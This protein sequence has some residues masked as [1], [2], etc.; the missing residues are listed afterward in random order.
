MKTSIK[1]LTP[2]EKALHGDELKQVTSKLLAFAP[3]GADYLE[4]LASPA[5]D[6]VAWL[7]GKIDRKKYDRW[8]FVLAKEAIVEMW[9]KVLPKVELK[10]GESQGGGGTDAEDLAYQ[11][12][13][14]TTTSAGIATAKRLELDKFLKL[15]S[16]GEPKTE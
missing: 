12:Q 2:Q 7:E 4:Q 1:P 15:E 5:K 16:G 6:Y 8:N 10:F 13:W 11:L 9:S 3:I 14:L